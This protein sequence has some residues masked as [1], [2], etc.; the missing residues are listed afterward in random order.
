MSRLT[1][2]QQQAEYESWL[3]SISKYTAPLKAFVMS[4]DG[5]K[6]LPDASVEAMWKDLDTL[7]NSVPFSIDVSMKVRWDK[8]GSVND[9][10]GQAMHIS[11]KLHD[12]M[13]LLFVQALKRIEELKAEL[14]KHEQTGR[15]AQ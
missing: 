3:E 10:A 2:K 7:R 14:K 8:L 5:V 4:T 9:G 13:V 11:A 15:A 6:S 12:N 1:K